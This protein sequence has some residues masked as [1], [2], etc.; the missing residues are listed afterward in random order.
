M[1]V[2][3]ST[4]LA[5]GFAVPVI[6][7][8]LVVGAVLV[9]FTQMER[10]KTTMLEKASFSAHVRNI[11]LEVLTGRYSTRMYVLTKQRGGA[12]AESIAKALS[13]AAYLVAHAGLVPEAA[14]DVA[15]LRDA[16]T[17]ISDRNVALEKEATKD[18]AA[19]LEASL[20]RKDGKFASAYAVIRV[21]LTSARAVRILLDRILKQADEAAA[22]S[23]VAFDAQVRA[24]NTIM[25]SIGSIALLATI[26]ITLLFGTRMR[27]RLNQ[28]SGALET[29]VRDDFTRLSQA[30]A[31]L[32]EGDLRSTF[33]SSRAP[34]G[35]TAHDEIGDLVRSYDALAD[36]FV[37]IGDQLAAG[38]AQLRELIGGVTL[39]SR[40]LAAAS[41]QTSAAAN[42]ASVAVDQIA[43]AVASVAGGAKEQAVQIAQAGA[44]IEELSRSAEMIADGATHQATAIQLATGGIQQ[45]DDGIG[46]LSAD[47]HDLARSARD[48]SEAVDGGNSAVTKTQ[49]AMRRLRTTSQSAAQAMVALEERSVQVEEIV[50]TIEAIAEQTNLLALNAAIE[51]ARAGDHGRGFAV[52][53]DEVR[54]LA[55]RSS[56]ATREIS[57]ILSA[58]RDET[59]TAADA[60][61]T[62]DTSMQD[63][64][65]LADRAAAAL[66]DVE[67]AITTTTGVAD[68]LAQRASAMRDA[69]LRVT[70]NVSTASAGVEENAAAAS[71][72]KITTQ[73]VTA[74]ILP[75]AA[76]AEEQSAAAHQA[77]LATGELASGV[78]EI[79]QT[80]R[81]LRDQAE[82]LD[83]LLARFVV[84]DRAAVAGAPLA[85]MRAM[86]LS[87]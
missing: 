76:A 25:L 45:L 71:Q 2:R 46:S 41:E 23:S 27:R 63:G 19:V 64:L 47:G 49:D 18:R 68:G 65:L 28:V 32:A 40:S 77:S 78:Q 29:M 69:S 42:E 56:L 67:R 3:I 24:A 31:R 84:D 48:V 82:R 51:A 57:A 73:D 81:A 21:N 43:R 9:G 1:R 85:G 55:E 22:A 12:Q 34:L 37:A 26:A 54:K 13:D 87:A 60:M 72:M 52:V 30:L 35:S 8:A 58:I 50:R 10:S 5:F 17:G 11:S 75:V 4:Q 39:A 53:A 80:A 83:T 66:Q 20:G 44:A 86:A 62:S 36:G 33:R 74:T 14:A 16:I 6:G 15:K 38:L 59:L 79:D 61:R 70:E 7:L